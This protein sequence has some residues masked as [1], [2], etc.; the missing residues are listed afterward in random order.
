M[1]KFLIICLGIVLSTLIYGEEKMLNKVRFIFD[2]RE[3]VVVLEK[4]VLPKVY[5]FNFH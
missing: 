5:W 2:N 3:I 1:K 4:I